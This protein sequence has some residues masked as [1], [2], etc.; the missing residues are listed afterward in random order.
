MIWAIYVPLFLPF[1]LLKDC[2]NAIV[3]VYEKRLLQYRSIRKKA[4]TDL[5]FV[6]NIVPLAKFPM[7]LYPKQQNVKTLKQTL[8]LVSQVTEVLR[9]ESQSCPSAEKTR[10]SDS[11]LAMGPSLLEMLIKNMQDSDIRFCSVAALRIELKA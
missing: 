1:F 5:C 4:I 7:L 11:S 10:D 9:L 6:T 8:F 3:L 2:P